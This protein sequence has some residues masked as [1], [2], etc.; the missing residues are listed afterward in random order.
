[1]HGLVVLLTTAEAHEEPLEDRVLA[2]DEPA[3]ML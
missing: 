1:M 2:V 3:G